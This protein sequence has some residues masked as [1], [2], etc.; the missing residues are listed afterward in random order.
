MR[1]AVCR[2][3][4][5]VLL[6][7]SRLAISCLVLQVDSHIRLIRCKLF[8]IYFVNLNLGLKWTLVVFA[9]SRSAQHTLSVPSWSLHSNLT[10][11]QIDLAS[12]IQ[13]DEPADKTG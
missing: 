5:L 3:K 8:S 6:R 12:K 9:T 2:C 4:L 13:Y 11:T 10:L 1:K 7:N